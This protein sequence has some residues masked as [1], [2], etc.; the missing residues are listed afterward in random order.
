MPQR[1]LAYTE[2]VLHARSLNMSQ[3]CLI[4]NISLLAEVCLCCNIHLSVHCGLLDYTREMVS[5]TT[6]AQNP[7]TSKDS[8]LFPL[9]RDATSRYALELHELQSIYKGD[10]ELACLNRTEAGLLVP[11]L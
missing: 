7:L 4:T 5:P 8:A 6:Q 11:E 1:R 10:R 2:S 3:Q 9:I